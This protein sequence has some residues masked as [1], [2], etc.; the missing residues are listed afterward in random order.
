MDY[1]IAILA[2][3]AIVFSLLSKFYDVDIMYSVIF[4]TSS[5][6]FNIVSKILNKREREKLKRDIMDSKRN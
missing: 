4:L 2:F 3:L 5:I 1:I 6:L